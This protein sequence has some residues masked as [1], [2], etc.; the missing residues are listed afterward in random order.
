MNDIIGWILF[1][2][3]VLFVICF[4]FVI[5]MGWIFAVGISVLIDFIKQGFKKN[6]AGPTRGR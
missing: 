4:A 6:D 1:G 2:V 3:A 5:T